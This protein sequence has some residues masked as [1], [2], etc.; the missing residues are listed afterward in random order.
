MASAAPVRDDAA[1][2]SLCVAVISPEDSPC[3]AALPDDVDAT[4][5]VH[6]SMDAF[7][8]H[9]KFHD[10]SA[11]VFVAAGGDVAL[12]PRVFDALRP[13]VRWVHSFFAGVDALLPFIT[14]HLQT[15]S[16]ATTSDELHSASLS[17]T[18]A[19]T[20]TNGRGAFSSSLAEHVMA[21]A[22]H[23]NKRITRCQ[24]NVRDKKWDKF[25]MPT[26]A[27]KTMG[28]VGFGH[29]GQTSARV[30]KAF[31]MKIV[32]LRRNKHKGRG[33]EAGGSDAG[34]ADVVYGPEDKFKLLAESDFVV[35][36][37]PGTS[38]T[39]D[40]FGP[41][42]F[43]AMKTDAAFI[44]VGRGLVVDEEA[45][46]SALQAGSIRGA[47][48]DVFKTEPLPETSKLWDCGDKL[49]MTAHNADYTEDYF[50]LGWDVWLQNRFS[51]RENG[52]PTTP[53]DIV[54]G[55]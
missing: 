49:L 12:V 15:Q 18:S 43:D 45:L 7:A 11:I 39:V 26:L 24:Q 52:V 20:L 37:L 14:S 42:E 50:A 44:S 32:C 53:V 16:P 38:E 3:L 6:N 2:P 13:N 5:L 30:A 29:I 21:S 28:F 46:A 51:L 54:A 22:L 1:A 35:S 17:T 25:V 23:F 4:F 34:L 9:P 31:G 33:G 27:G 8:A 55:Y 40:F 36:V 47:A 41:A 10:V 48:L 19:V